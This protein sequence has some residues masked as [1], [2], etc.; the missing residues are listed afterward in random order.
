M[1]HTIVRHNNLSK[2]RLKKKEKGVKKEERMA[3]NSSTAS[4]SK[5]SQV[6]N[7]DERLALLSHIL[8]VSGSNLGSEI[9]YLDR[10]FLYLDA[11]R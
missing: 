3:H 9:G 6:L 11:L 10:G 5:S 8:E 2:E 1:I 7:Y 4:V